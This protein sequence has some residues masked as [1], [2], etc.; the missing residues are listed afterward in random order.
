MKRD[1]TLMIAA[2]YCTF[3]AGE[4]IGTDFFH[5]R[6]HKVERRQLWSTLTHN[7]DI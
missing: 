4:F 6:Q 7:T 2:A 5:L 1:H 3:S